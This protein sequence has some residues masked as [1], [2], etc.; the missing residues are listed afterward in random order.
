MAYTKQVLLFPSTPKECFEMTAEAFDLAE[1]LQTPVIVMTDLD[2]GMNDHVSPPFEWDDSREY[3]RGKVL[4]AEA[5]E[6]I[7]RFGRY[8]DVD[9]D[10]ITYRT[11]PGTHP[12]KGSFFTRGTSRDEYAAYTE[13]GGAYRRN[14]DR[15]IKKW[16]T[17]KSY[18]PTPQLYQQASKYAN[19]IIFFG[20]SQY[21]A[22]EA[23]ELLGLQGIEM[24][25]LRIKAFPFDNNVEE[26]I[27]AHE[28]VFVIDQN[29][30]GQMRSLL[31]I[32]L[33]ANPHKLVSIL[34]YDGMP[35]TADNIIKQV[36]KTLLLN[37]Q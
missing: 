34:N 24:D 22:E 33:N 9:D 15:L 7:Q 2:L 8:L 18:V 17:A 37:Q 28:Q 31:M 35:I 30:D 27:N 1:Q 29:R 36:S 6:K 16:N 23:M 25:A 4:N 10:G 13:D 11:Y 19:G 12:T 20:T 26:F 3:K 32:E 5:L 14:M 21:A